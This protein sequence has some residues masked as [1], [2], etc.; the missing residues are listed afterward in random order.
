[1]G[2]CQ[3]KKGQLLVDLP[4]YQWNYAKDLWA[5]SRHSIEHR[6]PTHGLHDVLGARLPGGSK[7][8]PVWRNCLR[9]LDLPWLKHHSLGGE[10]VLLAA[11]YF[12]MAIEAITQ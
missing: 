10:V 4:T 6:T 12:G 9:M 2:K 5:E 7:T 1:M 8:E 3:L 11:G